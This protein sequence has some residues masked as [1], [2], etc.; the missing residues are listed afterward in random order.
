LEFNQSRDNLLQLLELEQVGKDEFDLSGT[1]IDDLKRRSSTDGKGK[2]VKSVFRISLL[3]STKIR[4]QFLPSAVEVK[5]FQYLD[6]SHREEWSHSIRYDYPDSLSKK[7]P[8]PI[9]S[10]TSKTEIGVKNSKLKYIWKDG[11][12]EKAPGQEGIVDLPPE[13]GRKRKSPITFYLMI[14]GATAGLGVAWYLLRRRS[15]MG[16]TA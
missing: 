10:V 1:R 5:T 9:Y 3:L 13:Q 4:N 7:V 8:L 6:N 15:A 11:D 2:L 16:G 14:G 12:Y